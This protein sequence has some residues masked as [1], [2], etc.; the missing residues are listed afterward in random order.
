MNWLITLQ[1]LLIWHVHLFS[2]PQLEKKKKTC[3]G[4]SIGPMMRS[5]SSVEDFSEDQDE[6]FYTTEIQ[7]LQHRWK[8]CVDSREVML[9]NKALLVNFDYCIK[10][11]VSLKTY[12]SLPLY[13]ERQKKRITSSERRTLKSKALK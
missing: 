3:L 1:M 6:S 5:L 9:K 11:F 12:F 8:N 2:V 10:Y 7:A 4:S 13:T